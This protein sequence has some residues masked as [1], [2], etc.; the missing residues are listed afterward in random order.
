MG[1]K[2]RGSRVSISNHAHLAASTMARIFNIPKGDLVEILIASALFQNYPTLAEELDRDGALALAICVPRFQVKVKVLN[3]T[4]DE[5][6]PS[7]RDS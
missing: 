4:R 5:E 7:D 3:A 1:L 6:A 2:T